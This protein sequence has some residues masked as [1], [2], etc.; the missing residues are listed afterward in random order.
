MGGACT[1]K[2]QLRQQAL[3]KLASATDHEERRLVAETAT[4][5]DELHDRR[6]T[7]EDSARTVQDVLNEHCRSSHEQQ[8]AAVIQLEQLRQKLLQHHQR[9]LEVESQV[10]QDSEEARTERAA[11]VTELDAYLASA[12]QTAEALDQVYQQ[13]LAESVQG[14]QQVLTAQYREIR[15]A[16]AALKA[17]L[18]TERGHVESVAADIVSE[19]S[20]IQA[21]VDGIKSQAHQIERQHQQKEQ[22]IAALRD[23]LLQL[24]Q[25]N[26]ALA[27]QQ[28]EAD[29]QI[30][31]L[32]SKVAKR[33]P[34]EQR[35]VPP[36][37]RPP[38]P[39]SPPLAGAPPAAAPEETE[40]TCAQWWEQTTSN[41]SA[42][43]QSFVTDGPPYPP[44]SSFPS[45][46]IPGCIHRTAQER[47]RC[48]I[49]RTLDMSDS[50]LLP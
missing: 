35:R 10:L 31:K 16:L 36:A 3:K 5:I 27:A 42:C 23:E 21:V 15:E 39:P 40:T 49:C 17:R 14:V 24:K 43:C 26:E 20:Q 33:E 8:A 46:P 38:P 7:I 13:S 48:A 30:K 12:E 50:S 44:S 28:Q 37:R 47:A 2:G 29:Q 11:Q 19:K 4:E 41:I 9:R 22:E 25:K 45:N 34:R 32:K 1:K 6:E 18:A